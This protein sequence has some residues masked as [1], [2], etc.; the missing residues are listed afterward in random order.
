[1]PVQPG[2][3]SGSHALRDLDYVNPRPVMPTSALPPEIRARLGLD[4]RGG[5][6]PSQ[7][8]ANRTSSVAAAP[9]ALDKLDRS[10][11][12]FAG[13]ATGGSNATATGFGGNVTGGSFAGN[14]TVTNAAAARRSGT[15]NGMFNNP[16]PLP[17]MRLLRSKSGGNLLRNG[18]AAGVGAGKEVAVS[19]EEQQVWEQVYTG[20]ANVAGGEVAF[21]GKA[22]HGADWV[23]PNGHAFVR[24]GTNQRLHEEK[25]RQAREKREQLD[26]NMRQRQGHG[27]F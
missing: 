7:N 16:A 21:A 9:R 17:K 18:G 13:N 10:L 1:M 25:V 14:N 15:T 4:N 26:Q 2:T 12:R 27:A 11:G 22:G 8:A 5:G 20:A 23:N 3:Q 6:R 24:R 19:E